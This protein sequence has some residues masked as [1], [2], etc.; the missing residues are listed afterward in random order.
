MGFES[1]QSMDAEQLITKCMLKIRQLRP[2]YSAIYESIPKIERSDISTIGVDTNSLYYNKEFVEK[3]PFEDFLFINLHE[4]G[5]L[6]LMHCSRRGTR[7]PELW[8]IACD[9]YVNAALAEEFGLKYGMTSIV[10]DGIMLRMPGDCLFCGS[11]DTKVDFVE[12]IYEKLEEQAKKNGY[13]SSKSN[14]GQSD[15]GQSMPGNGNG[16]GNSQSNDGCY[17]F[18]YRGSKNS[19]ENHSG[20]PDDFNFNLS[21]SYSKDVLE[22]G[23]DQSIK[24]QK[25]KKLITDASVRCDMAKQVGT[26]SGRIEVLSR[27]MI[28][29]VVN[30]KSLVKKYLIEIKSKDS[31]FSM[32]DKRMFYQDAIYPGQLGETDKYLDKVKVCIDTSGS[33]SQTDLMNFFGQVYGLLNTYKVEAELIYWDAEVQSCGSFSDYKEFSDIRCSGRGGTNPACVFE[34]LNKQK[35]KPRLVIMLTDGFL[36][37]SF[38]DGRTARRYKDTVWIM[39]KQYNKSFKPPFGKLAFAKFI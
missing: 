5:H 38:S 1:T 7:D 14:G 13:F 12:G 24:E 22:T 31:S 27:E 10:K 29:S 16:N 3:Q 17:S 4:I 23:E 34:Y 11:L 18:S 35:N 15:G 26:G 39:T 2:F 9:L 30:W 6:A 28:K 21:D 37:E 8:N 25:A 19:W 36:P 20:G 32:P 33:I